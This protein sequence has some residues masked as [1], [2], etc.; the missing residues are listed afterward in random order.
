VVAALAVAA[1]GLVLALLLADRQLGQQVGVEAASP[2]EQPAATGESSG[3]P[4]TEPAP[5]APPASTE[6][7]PAAPE[8]PPP[9]T[10]PGK[11]PPQTPATPVSR[12]FA[13]APVAGA[14]SYRVE[15]FRGPARIF[16]SNTSRPG[17]TVPRIWSYKGERQRLEPGEYR[18]Y[19][20]P[21]VAGTRSVEAVVRA[22][23]VI[24]DD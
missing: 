16:A 7:A 14:S 23:L 8:A 18:W 15:L 3:Q 20:W 4:S 12:R 10:E 13:W 22:R 21:V 17:I 2:T 9:S 19:V 6:P 1:A 11:T 5:E 24:E